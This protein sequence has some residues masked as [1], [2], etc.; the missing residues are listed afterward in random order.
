MALTTQDAEPDAGAGAADEPS[1]TD[2]ETGSIESDMPLSPKPPL[3]P[4]KRTVPRLPEMFLRHLS[5]NSRE[6]SM[7][8]ANMLSHNK[9]ARTFYVTSC[10]DGEGKTTAAIQM[11][12]GLAHDALARVLLVDWNPKSP[13]LADAFGVSPGSGLMEYLH[14]EGLDPEPYILQ[15]AYE[16]L[17]I[18]LLGQSGNGTRL[19]RDM[20][21]DKLTCLAQLYEYVIYDG[22]SLMGTSSVILASL[23]DGVVLVVEAE[24]TKWEVVQQARERINRINGAISGVVLNRRKYYIP[25]F[26]YGR[27]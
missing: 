23:F 27:I 19:Q 2:A 13:R 25:R 26:L 5:R 21:Y 16:N 12:W 3:P 6:L 9:E 11:A 1:E 24:K 4:E 15:T 10:F 18:M 14:Q 17:S 7:I 8:E 22:H 20:L